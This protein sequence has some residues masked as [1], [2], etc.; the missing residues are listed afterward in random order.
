[1]DRIH[2]F[3]LEQIESLLN[4][5]VG[6]TLGEIDSARVFDIAIEHPKVTGIAGMVIEQ[7]VLGYPADSRQE[8]DIKVDD[9][10]VEVKTTG[11]RRDGQSFKAKEPM[12]ITAVSPDTIVSEDF[13]T[14]HLWDKLEHMLL[15]YYLYASDTVVPAIGYMDFPVMG[16]EMYDIPEEDVKVIMQDWMT[17]KRCVEGLK[18]SGVER[19]HLPHELRRELMYLD[20]APKDRP[21][22][23]LKRSYVDSMVKSYFAPRISA[24]IPS[25]NRYSDLDAECHSL[26]ERFGGMSIE[27][28]SSSLGVEIGFS[29][30]ITEAVVVRMFGGK[31][32]KLNSIEQFSKMGLIGKCI[33]LSSRGGRTEDT[34][35]FPIDFD[36]MGSLGLSFEDSS[37]FDFFANHQLLCILFQE[38]A[39][40]SELSSNRFVGFK[41]LS[42]TEG[43]IETEVRRTWSEMNDLVSEKKIVESIVT[44]KDGKPR[45]NKTGEPMVQLN[46]PKSKDH[47]VFIRGSGKDSSSKP[48][49]VCGIDM[50]SQWA[51][52]RGRDIVRMLDKIRFL[53]RL[54]YRL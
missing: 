41:R 51:W 40:G 13:W 28:I 11:I 17:I 37:F 25:F 29:K 34:K 18:A 24:G 26:T 9:T 1:M 5:V 3:T 42:F 16:W 23:R 6:R 44:G 7:S 46:F 43:F 4:P 30:N 38:D 36:E 14:S 48:L 50:Y 15:V 33:S 10:E 2:R 12:S 19:I 45:I 31:A 20:T 32:K 47:S 35:L 39:P 22:F 54:R 52:I 49:R 27:S 21:R 8:C 53:R